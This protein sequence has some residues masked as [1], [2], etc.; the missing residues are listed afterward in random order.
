MVSK[1]LKRTETHWTNTWEHQLEGNWNNG[2]RC[3]ACLHAKRPSKVWCDLSDKVIWRSWDRAS[4]MYSFKYNQQDATLYNIL[5]YCQCS[6]CFRRFLRPSSGAQKFTYSI[7]YMPGLLAATQFHPD[8]AS[9]RSSETCMK[10]TSAE[11]TV[12][13]SWGWAERMPETCVEFHNRIKLG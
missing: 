5:Y 4:L 8:S 7:W 2:G 12:E 13:N 3:V 10:L 9:K 1:N 6:T 11:C